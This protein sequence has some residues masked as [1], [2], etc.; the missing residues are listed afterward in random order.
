ME[1]LINDPNRIKKYQPTS[2]IDNQTSDIN[3]SDKLQVYQ[4]LNLPDK[5]IKRNKIL[6]SIMTK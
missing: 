1:P 5:T 2:L 3:R 4:N 6:K